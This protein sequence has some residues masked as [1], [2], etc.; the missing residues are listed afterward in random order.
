[1]GT[2]DLLQQGEEP[3]ICGSIPNSQEAKNHEVRETSPLPPERNRI[4][5]IAH[6]LTG[7]QVATVLQTQSES[8][9]RNN[10][11]GFGY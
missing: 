7:E 8:V 3:P 5:D 4:C 9:K 6:A 2:T 10:F 11:D 1:M